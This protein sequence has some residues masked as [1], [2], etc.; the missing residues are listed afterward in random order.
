LT[1]EELQ[2]ILSAVVLD[3]SRT[4]ET[5]M[6]AV[7]LHAAFCEAVASDSLS[8]YSRRERIERQASDLSSGTLK[9]S[10]GAHPQEPGM[11]VF[12]VETLT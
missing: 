8:E 12:N 1:D 7:A 5:R 9:V 11:F 6:F 3:E 4:A 2:A 10:L